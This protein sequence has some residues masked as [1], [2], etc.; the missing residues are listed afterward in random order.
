M[1]KEFQYIEDFLNDLEFPWGFCHNDL[2]V[3]N[4][5]YDEQNGEGFCIYTPSIFHM[6]EV[7]L[8]S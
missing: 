1:R 2:H 7:E 4:V 5:L 8:L 6:E 3:S